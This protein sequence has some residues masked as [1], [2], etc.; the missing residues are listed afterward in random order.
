MQFEYQNIFISSN[1]VKFKYIF[2][3]IWAIDRTLSDTITLAYWPRRNIEE[4]Y[5]LQKKK[6]H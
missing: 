5:I 3:P 6:E 2:I 4:E 1:S